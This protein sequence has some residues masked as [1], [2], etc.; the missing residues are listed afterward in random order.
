M[1]TGGS[2][3]VRLRR[4]DISKRC[5]ILRGYHTLL[6][7]RAT[8]CRLVATGVS[9]EMLAGRPGKGTAAQPS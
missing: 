6:A 8:S 1:K 3:D 2:A 5:I 9:G 4:A 7:L